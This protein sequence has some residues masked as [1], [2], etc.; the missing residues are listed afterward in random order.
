MKSLFFSIFAIQVKKSALFFKM[1]FSIKT[2]SII[3]KNVNNKK[4]PP[5]AIIKIT[6]EGIK[7]YMFLFVVEAVRTTEK[8][9]IYTIIMNAH[10]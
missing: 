6:S 7:I 1:K 3:L 10:L 9:Y 5:E 2:T 8:L 4:I